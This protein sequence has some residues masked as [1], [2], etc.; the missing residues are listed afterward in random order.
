[1]QFE[2]DDDKALRNERLGRILFQDATLVFQD[3]NRITIQDT[4][5]RYGEARY[6]TYGCIDGRLFIVSH[7]QR[8]EVVRIISARKANAREKRKYDANKDIY[9]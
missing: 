6:N 3:E 5:Y 4:R 2:W 1:M 8:G 7:T 9:T